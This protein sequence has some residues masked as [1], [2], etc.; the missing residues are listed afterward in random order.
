MLHRANKNNIWVSSAAT[1][2]G[3]GSA[4]TP[5]SSISVAVEAAKPGETI[6]L[7]P[8]EYTE[9]L[10]VNERSGNENNPITIMGDPEGEPVILRGEWYFYSASD[11]I[12]S[13]VT[14]KNTSNSALS[15]IG[16]SKR[17]IFKKIVFQNCGA[18]ANCTLFVGGSGG[19]GNVFEACDFSMIEES[20]DHI[21]IM[22]SQSID[23]ED[24]TIQLSRN[25]IV[26]YCTFDQFGTAILAGSG[27]DIQEYGYISVED[28]RISNCREG[29]RI[30]SNGCSLKGMIFRNVT[31]AVVHVE[32]V[33]ADIFDNRFE[34]C[35]TALSCTFGEI[36]IHENCFVSSGLSIDV[37]VCGLPIIAHNNSF[38]YTEPTK[39]LT[40]SGEG[41]CFAVFSDNLF[42]NA[43]LDTFTGVHFHGNL[44]NGDYAVSETTTITFEEGYNTSLIAGC[45]SPAVSRTE[46]ELPESLELSEFAKEHGFKTDDLSGSIEKRELFLK[47]MFPDMTDEVQEEEGDEL[48]EMEDYFDLSTD[49]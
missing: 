29:V 13:N 45:H 2:V 30:K 1:S 37:E 4:E 15:I 7:L 26:R 39:A 20:A 49:D 35:P 19:E 33:D 43:Q 9:S 17:N 5:F 6:I 48:E 14:F 36:T 25:S 32:G 8:G 41:E 24:A 3:D 16:D 27:D 21:G 38:I 22:L 44:S 11:F 47:S 31:T 46:I 12:V 34:E 28:S 23:E 10:S 18:V 40:I 42:Y